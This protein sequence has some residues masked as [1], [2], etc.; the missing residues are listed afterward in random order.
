MQSKNN[1]A[2]VYSLGDD[3]RVVVWMVDT[4]E[5]IRSFQFQGVYSNIK[6]ISQT[7]AYAI[8]DTTFGIIDFG[9]TLI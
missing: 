1:Q 2:M 4:F 8:K 6:A 9:N 3:M 7:Q 5:V